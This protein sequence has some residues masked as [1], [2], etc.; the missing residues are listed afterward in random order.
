M[1]E[2]WREGGGRQTERDRKEWRKEGRKGGREEE[3]R[4][5]RV[6]KLWWSKGILLADMQVCISLVR[7]L[8]RYQT[9]WNF[10][11]SYNMDSLIH[12]RSLM[13]NRV[14]EGSYWKESK[15]IPFLMISVLRAACNFTCSKIETDREQ[16][17]FEKWH[18]KEEKCNIFDSLKLNVP[19]HIITLNNPFQSSVQLNL[20][21]F[22][23]SVVSDS[24]QPHESQ[25]TMLPC[26]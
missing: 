10:I 25:H 24:L 4:Q 15:Q 26:P 5:K 2:S 14:T 23:C 19:W 8:H 1:R 11:K 22:S 18:T 13:L 17:I 3:R 16:R 12:T 9:G 6:P 7:W 20:V 21:P